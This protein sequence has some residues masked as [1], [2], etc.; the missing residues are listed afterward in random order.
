MTDERPNKNERSTSSRR[1]VLKISGVSLASLVGLGTLGAPSV[2]AADDDVNTDFDPNK[3]KEV[4]QFIKQTSDA[5]N[6]KR[7]FSELDERQKDAV[8]RALRPQQLKTEYKQR[9]ASANE[10]DEL[11]P[12]SS[13]ETTTA[14][15]RAYAEGLFPYDELWSFGVE[16]TW[17]HNGTE[18]KNLTSKHATQTGHPLWHF[19]KIIDE[20]DRTES[21]SIECYK[22]GK[23]AFC[24][25]VKVGCVKS[26][27]PYIEIHGDDNGNH[28]AD[29]N[30][31]KD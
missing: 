31:K 2:A 10:N 12:S 14:T 15:Y 22:Q 21:D 28:S 5:E 7:I 29:S 26:N 24:D 6:F 11:S 18:V 3:R 20:S 13:W 9:P 25:P 27:T 1:S 8:K 19:K 16:A 30:Y 4:F 23:F 17:E